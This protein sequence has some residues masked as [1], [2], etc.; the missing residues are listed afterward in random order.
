ML[1]LIFKVKHLRYDALATLK[2]IHSAERR[3]LLGIGFL[4]IFLRR[5]AIIARLARRVGDHSRVVK[6]TE[7]RYCLSC[8]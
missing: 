7:K 6:N 8:I 2:I 1:G 4:Q 5:F 3:P